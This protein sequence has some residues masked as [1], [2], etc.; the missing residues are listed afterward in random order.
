[1]ELNEVHP[2]LII[3]HTLKLINNPHHNL[4]I[5]PPFQTFT[6]IPL[7]LN[8][9]SIVTQLHQKDIINI[10]PILTIITITTTTTLILKTFTLSHINII[11]VLMITLIM[12]PT[13]IAHPTLKDTIT[14]H[15]QIPIIVPN[16][17]TIIIITI[18]TITRIH[19][20]LI[21]TPIRSMITTITVRIQT[22]TNF[23]LNHLII[24]MQNLIPITTITTLNAQNPI[25]IHIWNL[26]TVIPIMKTTI[27]RSIQNRFTIPILNLTISP[28][29]NLTTYRSIQTPFTI[30]P[31]Q[32]PTTVPLWKPIIIP[33][34]G[35]IQNLIIIIPT[36]RNITIMEIIPALFAT[37]HHDDKSTVSYKGTSLP[38]K[39]KG[40]ELERIMMLQ[41]Q[42]EDLHNTLQQTAV[43]MECLGAEFITGHQLLESELQ[44]TRVELS[45]MMDKFTRLQDNYSSTQQTNHL[46]EK[47]LHCVAESMDGE[48]EK[49]NQRI[50]ELTEQLSA[51]KTTIQSLETI[52]V[53]SMLQD[54]LVKHFKS[55]DPLKPFRPPVAPPPVQF[56][57]SDHYDKGSVTGDEQILGPLPEE[58]ESDWSEMGDEAQHCTLRGSQGGHHVGTA[59]SPWRQGTGRVVRADQ[60]GRGDGDTESESGGEEVVR[61]CG[62]QIP[63][64][65]FTIHP[66]TL[67]VPL[68]D[69]SLSRFKQSLTGPVGESHHFPAGRHLGSPIRILSASLEGINSSGLQQHEHHGQLKCMEGVMDLHHPQRGTAEDSD[70]E[71][72]VR[73]WKRA[74][75]QE[76]E[77]GG[78]GVGKGGSE[79]VGSLASLESAQRMLNH[80]IQGGQRTQL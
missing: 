57:D 67:P 42:N 50:S 75:N 79:P 72:L 65:Q 54:A 46:L 48:R 16:L 8:P 3:L 71:E 6:S 44:R 36:L 63:H 18:I 70:E 11:L 68:T 59:F 19:S 12:I 74:N 58:E 35:I 55:D 53:T 21:I 52:N 34:L 27:I 7:I 25:T 37:L 20:L 24:P 78:R 60:Y 9:S 22:P 2:Q 38:L 69:A 73:N 64:L 80:F 61:G 14:T 32:N 10:L 30:I 40:S 4:T 66:E 77:G 26:T 49:L 51:A 23:I 39:E 43:R 31:I 33:T 15:I 28:T 76:A 56:M 13:L 17:K 45:S 5:I 62:L 29:Q 47:K 1:M 41:E